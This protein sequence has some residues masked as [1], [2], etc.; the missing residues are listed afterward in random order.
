MTA[1]DLRE[2]QARHGYTYDTAAV[3]LGVSRRTY[4]GYLARG[5]ELPRLLELACKA[6]DLMSL[7]DDLDSQSKNGAKLR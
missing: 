5:E 1:N 2:W 4:A 3:A 7:R 6:L